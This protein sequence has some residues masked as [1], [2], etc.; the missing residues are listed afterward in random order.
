MMSAMGNGCRNFKLRIVLLTPLVL[1]STVVVCLLAATPSWAGLPDGRVDELVSPAGNGGEPYTDGAI[2]NDISN[3]LQSEQ[4][5]QAADDG[6][7]MTYVGEPPATVGGEGR[8]GQFA[9][10]QWLATRTATGWQAAV[11]TPIN[12]E[13]ENSYFVYQAFSA[14]LTTGYFLGISEALAPEVPEKCESLYA[15]DAITGTYKG[16]VT[17]SEAPTASGLCGMPRFAGASADEA[18]V[19]F[20]DEAAL[21]PN[22]QPAA[23][24]PV[25]RGR[26]EGSGR[27]GCMFGCN[28]YESVA[29]HLRLVNVIEGTPVASAV[30]GGY[31]GPRSTGL[32]D[33]SN[34]ISADG[35]RIFWTDTQEGSD[36]EHVYAL[37][38]GS[39]SVQVS[40]SGAA[41]YWTATPDGRY[42]YYTEAGA[43]WR[44]DT[45]SNTREVIAPAA[46]GVVGV[47]GLNE[48]GEDED[49]LYFVGAGALAQGATPKLCVSYGAQETRLEEEL[50]DGHI[51]SEEFLREKRLVEVELTEE[52]LGETPPKTGCNLYVRHG[53]ETRFIA[54]LSPADNER[55]AHGEEFGGV[56]SG[57]W[58]ASLG[59]RTAEL[60]PD[61]RHLVFE[62]FRSLTGYDN[63]SQA[64]VFVY[65][66]DTDQVQ[67]ASC[68][69]TGA[70]PVQSESAGAVR[71]PV[72]AASET[73]M[74]RWIS[75]DGSR[76][77]FD[78]E[79]AL[80]PQDRNDVQDVY[81]W[82]RE[83]TP[84]CPTATSKFG[85][86][87]SLLSGGELAG[88]SFL[89]D[90]DATGDNVFFEQ[91]GSLGGAE[92]GADRNELY[93][94]RVDDGFSKPVV[95]CSGSGCHNEA[96]S[97]PSFMSPP[98]ASFTGTG[99]LPATAPP[100]HPKPAP[101]TR[102]QQLTK[103]LKACRAMR[104]KRR[105]ASCER[106]AHKRFGPA[107]GAKKA[108]KKTNKAQG[109][110]RGKQ[111]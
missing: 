19:I 101:Q 58:R 72:S 62:S 96:P 21:T 24:P 97:S 67:C 76:V 59:E 64:E 71:L 8:T 13:T 109:A 1:L 38:D 63:G 12:P 94:A 70:A 45:S 30:F 22:A 105:R 111:S 108:N 106:R 92:V 15:R 81:E 47:I 28:L 80:V 87:V 79:Q 20:Q 68:A 6:E 107:H 99:N 26:Q 98:S 5:F 11:I 75:S 42:A 61:G 3:V 36:F 14:D 57:A 110:G 2:N 66:S 78:S 44:F 55:A 65:A 9:G 100:P 39:R 93:D 104:D 89:I 10:D 86:C 52:R 37:E 51:S 48:T 7:Q 46:G 83:G 53:G 32:T 35:S 73:Y 88:Y 23:E 85:G 102:A 17:P 84:G 82:E 49:Y 27:E 25:E 41:E 33:L 54:T 77:F 95:V 4:P 34:A 40:G 56:H 91:R 43:L 50:S 103:A 29:G 90:A 74:H 31:P 69:P 16:L 18:E 60:T